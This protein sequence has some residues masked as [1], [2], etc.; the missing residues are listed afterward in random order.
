MKSQLENFFGQYVMSPLGILA[1]LWV[2]SFAL[3]LVVGSP[4][5]NWLKFR[6]GMKWAPREDT[7]DTH[8]QKAG[9]PSIGGIGIIGAATV[10]WLAFLVFNIATTLRIYPQLFGAELAV[11]VAFYLSSFSCFTCRLRIFR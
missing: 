7:P 6:K 4:L 8:L 3:M 10:G 5:I 2:L 9:V 1:I 11:F